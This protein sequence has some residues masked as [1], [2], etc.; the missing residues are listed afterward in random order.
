MSILSTK[1]SALLLLTGL[2]LAAGFYAH[3][4]N[5]RVQSGAGELDDIADLHTALARAAEGD[6]HV[7]MFV[8]RLSDSCAGG[9]RVRAAQRLI[10]TEDM[11]ATVLTRI[12]YTEAEIA[13]FK[14]II[15]V[16]VPIESA[17]AL[18]ISDVEAGRCILIEEQSV[19]Y[20]SRIA[21]GSEEAAL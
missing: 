7:F 15:D 3:A 19:V 13:S 12:D 21:D 11:H 6:S 4:T 2:F 20:D 14:D 17:S 18:G 9:A 10:E 1:R 16:D 5:F 8:D